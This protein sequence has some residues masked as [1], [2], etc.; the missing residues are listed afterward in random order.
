ML[1][2]LLIYLSQA[3][4]MR[5]LVMGWS[6]ARKVAL[7]FV[8]GESLDQA[9]EVV[10]ILNQQSMLATMDQLGEH[11]DTPEQARKT[12]KDILEILN[13]IDQSGVKS[14]LS[15][16]LSQI[17]LLL[18]KSL[19]EDNLKQILELADKHNIFVRIDMEDSPCIDVTLELY[20]KMRREYGYQNVGMVIQ[21][22]LY[23][24]EQDT[25]DLLADGTRIR[26]VKGAYKEPHDI[27]F[28]KKKDVDHSFDVLTEMML[29]AAKDESSPAIS[30]DGRWPPVTAVASHDELRIRNSIAYAQKLGIP[31][32]KLE[33]QMLYGIRR[34]LQRQL[35]EDGY[36][37]RIY[38]PFGTEWYP[39]F[40]RRL[41]ERPANL[42]FFISSLL[43]D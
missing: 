19:C 30:E 36:P 9:I 18:D 16:K 17:G 38:V 10:K 35:A 39:Y 1:R 11:T 40:M 23:R 3:D 5:R 22:Y 4:W 13:K 26:M 41:A 15:V 25:A 8:A 28:P 7:R 37:V 6:I 43:R 33:F 20:W 12:T 2:S 27:A 42:W 31:K 29:D 24:S 14:G 21:S 34:E 32:S